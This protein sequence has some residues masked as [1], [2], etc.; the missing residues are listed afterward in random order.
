[1]AKIKGVIQENGV[2]R[3]KTDVGEVVDVPSQFKAEILSLQYAC[4]STTAA[5][6][7]HAPFQPQTIVLTT[8]WIEIQIKFTVAAAQKAPAIGIA[9]SGFADTL[10]S[11][12]KS[13]FRILG[14]SIWKLV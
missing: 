14:E 12:S 7:L 1:M 9:G 4:P 6:A 10:Q 2:F 13:V 3:P 5:Q 8:K 11:N